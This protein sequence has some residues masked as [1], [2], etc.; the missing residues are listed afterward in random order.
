VVVVGEDLRRRAVLLETFNASGTCTLI[1]PCVACTCRHARCLGLAC[2]MY[3]YANITAPCSWPLRLAC[4]YTHTY[5]PCM[6]GSVKP[7]RPRPAAAYSSRRH[8]VFMISLCRRT[9]SIWL[10]TALHRKHRS[11]DLADGPSARASRKLTHREGRNLA[12]ALCELLMEI[13]I[14][15]FVKPWC[16]FI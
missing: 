13:V 14:T 10:A 7:S 9:G 16:S 2:I 5:A 12:A 1:R 3:V 11:F 8:L 6:H 4:T 15:L